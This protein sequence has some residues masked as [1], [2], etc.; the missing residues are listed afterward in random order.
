MYYMCDSHVIIT[1]LIYILYDE[2]LMKTLSF[3]KTIFGSNCINLTFSIVRHGLC[4]N[5]NVLHCIFSNVL[6]Y[7]EL[8]AERNEAIQLTQCVVYAPLR[9]LCRRFGWLCFVF[10]FQYVYVFKSWL[11]IPI[12]VVSNEIINNLKLIGR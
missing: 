6:D 8:C 10:S 9:M 7:N 5:Y 3:R 12:V 2:Y 11:L 4:S 1:F